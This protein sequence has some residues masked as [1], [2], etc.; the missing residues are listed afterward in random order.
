MLQKTTTDNPLLVENKKWY[1]YCHTRKSSVA[2]SRDLRR[3]KDFIGRLTLVKT[4][5]YAIVNLA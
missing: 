1:K 2:K 5:A 4:R 3:I